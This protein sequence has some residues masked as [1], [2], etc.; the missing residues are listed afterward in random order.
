M[1]IYKTMDEIK[2]IKKANEI[3][4]RL[5]EDVLPQYIKPGI[6][7][8]ELD[9]ISEDYM[10]SQGAIPGTKGYDIGRPYPPYPAA[11]CI[12]V[13]EVVVHGIPS[14][15]QIL[16]E[17]DILTIDTVTVLDGYFGDAAITYA[18][19][20]IDEEAKKLMEV[21]MWKVLDSLL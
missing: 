17:G 11:T 13:N 21:T 12:S 15:K 16:K 6:S 2:K 5:F 4:A 10:R 8:H 19:G 9:Q 18:V 1:I 3:I 14:K 7:T 20:E